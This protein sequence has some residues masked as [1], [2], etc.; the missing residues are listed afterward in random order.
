MIPPRSHLPKSWRALKRYSFDLPL[1]VPNDPSACPR[2]RKEILEYLNVETPGGSESGSENV[3]QFDVQFVRTAQVNECKYWLWRFKAD[4]DLDCYVS[5]QQTPK[6]D[7]VLG[8][9]ETFD[10]APEQWLV[11]DYYADEDWDDEE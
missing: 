6:G 2:T 9:D 8:Y 10:L 5:V 1:L 4:E 11:L 3:I 7:S